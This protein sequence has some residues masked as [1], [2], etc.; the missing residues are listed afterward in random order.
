MQLHLNLKDLN[1]KIRQDSIILGIVKDFIPI[2]LVKE[3]FI[4]NAFQDFRVLLIIGVDLVLEIEEVKVVCQWRFQRQIYL[5]F[6]QITMFVV[7]LTIYFCN[8]STS[9]I[10]FFPRTLIS[11]LATTTL[12][13]HSHDSYVSCNLNSLEYQLTSRLD[14]TNHVTLDTTNLMTK[15]YYTRQGPHR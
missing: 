5:E 13:K 14:A 10:I 11:R 8:A 2:M 9:L 6:Q 15:V 1:N 7:S 3:I 12:A 4:D